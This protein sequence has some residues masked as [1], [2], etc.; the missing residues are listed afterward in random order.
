MSLMI[1]EKSIYNTDVGIQE[2]TP[3]TDTR[4]DDTF[5]LTIMT[6]DNNEIEPVDSGWTQVST[7]STGGACEVEVWYK[8]VTANGELPTAIENISTDDTWANILLVRGLDLTN[9]IDVAGGDYVSTSATAI[10]P[11]VT[12]TQ[13]NQILLRVAVSDGQNF[14]QPTSIPTILFETD[15]YMG[16]TSVDAGATGTLEIPLAAADQWA[17]AT[18]IL[19]RA[20]TDTSTPLVIKNDSGGYETLTQVTGQTHNGND[21]RDIVRATNTTFDVKGTAETWSVDMSLTPAANTRIMRFDNFSTVFPV[22]DG[23]SVVTF[24]LS[25]RRCNIL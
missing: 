7:S 16:W 5:I 18:V 25:C 2:F 3:T 4:I 6:K 23:T 21:W 22:G 10:C 15:F 24:D 8:K 1:D 11:S 19:K 14:T 20:V 13:D 12:S 9:P 17:A